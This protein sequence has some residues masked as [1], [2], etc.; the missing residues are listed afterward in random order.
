MTTPTDQHWHRDTDI[1]FACGQSRGPVPEAPGQHVDIRRFQ[2]AQVF[3]AGFQG[4]LRQHL[5]EG[6][7]DG[8]LIVHERDSHGKREGFGGVPV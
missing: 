8:S 2:T 7:G 1:L 5:I 3:I 4:N 6:I